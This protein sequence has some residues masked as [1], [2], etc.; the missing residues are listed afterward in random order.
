MDNQQGRSSFLVVLS[1][2]IQDAAAMRIDRLIFD[3]RTPGVASV[4][5][6]VVV[7]DNFLA[8]AGN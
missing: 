7:I 1:Y 5:H 3:R 2:S 8:V 4:L 6:P